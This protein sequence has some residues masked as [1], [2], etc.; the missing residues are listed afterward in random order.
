MDTPSNEVHTLNTVIVHFI[1]NHLINDIIDCFNGDN[2]DLQ[3][4]IYKHT[5]S[6]INDYNDYFRYLEMERLFN[7]NY[8]GVKS[9]I[10][11][12]CY[13]DEDNNDLKIDDILY[14]L[15]RV[16]E[17]ST[18]L[19]EIDTEYTKQFIFDMYSMYITEE[20]LINNRKQWVEEEVLEKNIKLKKFIM[21]MEK[22]EDYRIEVEP[23]YNL[24]TKYINTLNKKKTV[25][26]L[27]NTTRLS[28]DLCEL[29]SGLS[30]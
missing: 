13:Y 15:R 4:Y 19:G 14:I 25:I 22:Q 2:N 30:I 10:D 26:K 1:N 20:V 17:Y 23:L 3:N 6:S 5:A 16:E 27:L 12:N 28:P 18:G 11:T 7:E 29:I 9:V 24:F 21:N 8:D